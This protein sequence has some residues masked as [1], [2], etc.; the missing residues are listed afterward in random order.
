MRALAQVVL[1][2]TKFHD[3]LL[4]A[5]AVFLDDGFDLA[6]LEQRRTDLDVVAIGEQ[7]HVAKGDGCARLRVELLDLED[8]A[9][10]HSILF[11]ARGDDRVHRENSGKIRSGPKP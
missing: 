9:L 8:G 5:L 7:Q 1:A 4:V 11:A 6:T 10:F 3:D 2:A